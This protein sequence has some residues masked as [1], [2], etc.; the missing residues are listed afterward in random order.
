MLRTVL[1]VSLAVLL[2]SIGDV[3]MS[4]AM[5][6]LGPFEWTG[7]S[8]LGRFLL[9]ALHSAWF[10]VAVAFMAGHF[11]L[12]LSVLSWAE[13]SVAVPLTALQYVYNAV[14]A[15]AVLGERVNS[16]RWWGTAVIM[17][18]VLMLTLGDP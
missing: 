2:S 5:R 14:L 12:W 11:F 17:T 8:S 16:M 4:R 10:W 9:T 15:Q 7:L 1:I 3:L 6:R 13:L 18:G